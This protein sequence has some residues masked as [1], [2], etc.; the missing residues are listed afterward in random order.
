MAQPRQ[1]LIEIDGAQG[2]GGGQ[3]L[4]SA[5]T[6]S[7]LTGHGVYLYNIRAS[8]SK[9][10]LMAQ[11]LKSVDA[12]A[13]V[14]KASVDGASINS[15]SLTFRPSGLRSGRYRFEIGTA[16]ATSLVLQTIFLP[17]SFLSSSSSV[18]ISGGTHV[19]WSPCYHYLA[20]NWLPVLQ[21]MGFDAQVDFEQ[22]GFYPSGGGRI[23][24]T[25]RPAIAISPLTL[26]ERGK[27]LHIHG[28]SAVANLPISIADRQKRQALLRLQKLYLGTAPELRIQVQQLQSPAKG[29]FLLLLAEFESGR[30][31]YFGLGALGKPAE[32]VADEAVDALLS[33]LDTDGAIDQYLADQLLIP[34]SLANG[35]SELCTSRVTEHLLTNAAVL[36]AFLPTR[37][38]IQGALGQP[39]LIRVTPPDSTKVPIGQSHA[40]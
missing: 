18:M 14:C 34:L 3:V 29:T 8:R 40:G 4:R 23:Q 15:T 37:I 26:T 9:P 39:G 11:H 13:A 28:I 20:L 32:R 36:H 25:I 17:L 5:L 10:G 31:C 12:T 33:F 6:L 22:A 19:P 7:A 16:G 27:L 2:E 1:S 30:C 24:S 35:P 38:E 21:Q